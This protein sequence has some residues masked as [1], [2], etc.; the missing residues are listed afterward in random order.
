MDAFLKILINIFCS[1]LPSSHLTSYTS[2]KKTRI[3]QTLALLFI[4]HT[5]FTGMNRFYRNRVQLLQLT[6]RGKHCC[7]LQSGEFCSTGIR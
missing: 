2:L 6:Q 3:Q 7:W 4:V 1:S 5:R